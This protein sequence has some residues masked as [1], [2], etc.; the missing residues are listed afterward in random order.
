[1][2]CSQQEIAGCWCAPA[3]NPSTLEQTENVQK[4][5]WC[6]GLPGKTNTPGSYFLN[7]TPG[8][9]WSAGGKRNKSI[10]PDRGPSRSLVGGRHELCLVAWL[11]Q[12]CGGFS[13]TGILSCPG[14]Q[15]VGKPHSFTLR[16]ALCMDASSPHSG[17]GTHTSSDA[18]RAGCKLGVR[19]RTKVTAYLTVLWLVI[20]GFLFACGT[21]TLSPGS[22]PS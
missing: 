15:T 4:Q 22:F 19:Y 5:N 13:H 8:R 12:T 21:R 11:H 1:M 3:W 17:L 6:H 7:C 2:K 14:S 16:Q 18:E 10:W 9:V 20:F